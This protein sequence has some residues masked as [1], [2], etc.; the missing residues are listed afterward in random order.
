MSDKAIENAKAM[1]KQLV[2]RRLVLHK[3][4]AEIDTRIGQIDGF[5]AAWQAFA[6]TDPEF[7]VE[8]LPLASENKQRKSPDTPKRA[9][10]NSSKEEVAEAALKIIHERGSPVM[11][12]DLYKELLGRGLIIKG[13][14][15]EMVLSTMLWRMQDKIVRLKSGGYWD[16][17]KPFG[18]YDPMQARADSEQKRQEKEERA[19]DVAALQGQIDIE[20]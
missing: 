13:K 3:E 12:A 10:G 16:A 6:D 8:S 15:P 11:R 1:K 19:A 4:I 20:I 9:T 7:A 2:D 17:D 5:I 14:D 18:N